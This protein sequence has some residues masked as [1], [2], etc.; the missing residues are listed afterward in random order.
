MKT[1]KIKVL[2]FDGQPMTWWDAFKRFAYAIISWLFL[3][4][5]F[6]WKFIDKK[7]YTWHDHLSKT[8]LFFE[9]E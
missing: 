5:G 8:S 4:C 1:W 7:Q 9:Q 6:L 3:G 2:T